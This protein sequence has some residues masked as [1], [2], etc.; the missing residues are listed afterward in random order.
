MCQEAK[1]HMDD[2]HAIWRGGLSRG[3]NQL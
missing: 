1:L 3:Y 2:L